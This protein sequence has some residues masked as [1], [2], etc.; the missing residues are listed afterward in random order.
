MDKQLQTTLLDIIKDDV[1][2]P[3]IVNCM[4]KATL[5][6]EV[7][8]KMDY[9]RLYSP[10][11]GF[12]IRDQDVEVFKEWI[13]FFEKKSLGPNCTKF[14]KFM[15]LVVKING[16]YLDTIEPYAM[17]TLAFYTVAKAILYTTFEHD[18]LQP[19]LERAFRFESCE[20]F[21]PQITEEFFKPEKFLFD[22]FL[23]S[24]ESEVEFFNKVGDLHPDI[25]AFKRLILKPLQ[26]Q[27]KECLHDLHTNLVTLLKEL[28]EL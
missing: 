1:L 13:P 25:I 5:I 18:D 7:L 11:E 22:Y 24:I 15:K 27:Y 23:G 8:A 19:L 26:A 17:K 16:I 14:F 21:K 4:D 12:N 2:S 9:Q 28:C 6:A 20:S 3:H 10:V